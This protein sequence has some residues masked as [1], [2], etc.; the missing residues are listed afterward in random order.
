MQKHAALKKNK[1]NQINKI[2]KTKDSI[3]E[4]YLDLR[5]NNFSNR[6]V[7]TQQDQMLIYMV[8]L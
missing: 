8:F 2:P 4:S 6:L 1:L 3:G 5:G 7:K